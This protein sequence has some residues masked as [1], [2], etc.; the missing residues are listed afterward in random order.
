MQLDIYPV[1]VATT[2]R[3]ILEGYSYRKSASLAA[4]ERVEAKAA[5]PSR[6]LDRGL[7][8]PD[9]RWRVGFKSP[10]HLGCGQ[11]LCHLCRWKP[12]LD[13]QCPKPCH[14]ERGAASPIPSNQRPRL[15]EERTGRCSGDAGHRGSP[16]HIRH[17]PLSENTPNAL[18]WARESD[19][20]R[21]LAVHSRV[22]SPTSPPSAQQVGYIPT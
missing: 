15:A 14:G 17:N 6:G 8:E 13:L 19:K 3:G 20:T 16:A 2:L 11:R 9:R 12:P 22:H 18:D 10:Q 4:R 21:S 1:Y 5:V 7:S